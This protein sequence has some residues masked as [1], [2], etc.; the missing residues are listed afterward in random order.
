MRSDEYDY[1]LESDELDDLIESALRT[2]PMRP[3][4]V[5]LHRKVTDRMRFADLRERQVARFRYSMA[6][7]GLALFGALGVAGF[8]IAFTNFELLMSNG[9]PGATGL[10][11]KYAVSMSQTWAHYSGAYLMP[12]LTVMACGIGA[13]ALWP[14]R[15]YLR[16]H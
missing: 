15:K 10:Y 5:D 6:S 14:L 3:A 13:A 16:T 7:L 4:P 12:L 11:D 8:A 2:E 9:L 1:L